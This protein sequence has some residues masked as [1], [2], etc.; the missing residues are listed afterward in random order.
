MKKIKFTFFNTIIIAFIT[1]FFAFAGEVKNT[2]TPIA[3]APAKTAPAAK[4]TP[5]QNP[6]PS[7]Q[8][9]VPAPTPTPAM[10]AI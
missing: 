2:A 1:T 8:V 6:A 7:A 10:A 3:P 4:Q 9:T 5:I